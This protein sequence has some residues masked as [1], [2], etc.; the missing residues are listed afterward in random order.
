MAEA[1]RS[2]RK[3]LPGSFWGEHGL[4]TPLSCLPD[5][6][7][8]DFYCFFKKTPGLGRFVTAMSYTLCLPNVR[9]SEG[10]I[11]GY[12]LALAC[13]FLRFGLCLPAQILSPTVLRNT[14]NSAQEVAADTAHSLPH[15]T[16]QPS[17]LHLTSF[18]TA[19]HLAV[20]G[21]RSELCLCIS[22]ETCAF[23]SRRKRASQMHLWTP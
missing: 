23:E 14:P 20:P 16:S 15:C 12:H 21:A 8:L 13:D 19:P 10:P 7:R 1:T 18:P 6:C 22:T 4:M 11:L 5:M 17:P 9:I 2:M 3:D